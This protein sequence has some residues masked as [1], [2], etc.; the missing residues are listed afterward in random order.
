MQGRDALIEK[1][2]RDFPCL[3][4][5][6]ARRLVIAYGTRAWTI[7]GNAK[8]HADLGH[9]FGGTLFEADVRHA[10]EQEMAR[11]ADDVL[12]RR[13]KLGL[14]LSSAQADALDEW[15]RGQHM[16]TRACAAAPEKPR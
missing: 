4:P 7:L 12:W 15:M 3:H 8:S 10:I 9:D 11:T 1:M 14:D 13:S 6:H 2:R 16:P 5:L